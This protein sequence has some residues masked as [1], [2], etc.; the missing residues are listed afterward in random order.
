M[1]Q[2]YFLPND[3]RESDRLG[4]SNCGLDSVAGTKA[5]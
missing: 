4:K 1:I 2:E 5:P 3:E